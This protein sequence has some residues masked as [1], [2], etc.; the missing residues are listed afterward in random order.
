M[1]NYIIPTVAKVHEIYLNSIKFQQSI[2]EKIINTSNEGKNYIILSE[3]T[4]SQCNFLTDTLR[5]LGYTV[6]LISFLQKDE[7]IYWTVEIGW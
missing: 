2:A 7:N 5:A 1:E 3:L 4:E 6:K